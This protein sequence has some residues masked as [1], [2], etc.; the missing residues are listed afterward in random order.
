MY[1]FL[2]PL[3]MVYMCCPLR[4]DLTRDS[5]VL[6]AFMGLGLYMSAT[7]GARAVEVGLRTLLFMVTLLEVSVETEHL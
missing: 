5:D 2:T 3:K 4:Y 6:E 7:A 1:S